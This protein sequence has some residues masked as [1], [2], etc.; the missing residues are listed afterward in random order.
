MGFYRQN[1]WSGVPFP[2][3]GDLPDP[4]IKP[5]SPKSLMSPALAGGFFTTSTTWEA[6]GECWSPPNPSVHGISPARILEWV[7]MSFSRWSSWPRDQSQV[8]CINSRFFVI[9]ATREAPFLILDIALI[10]P[11][12]VNRLKHLLDKK[13][14]PSIKNKTCNNWTRHIVLQ[15]ANKRN[16]NLQT[17]IM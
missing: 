14:K 11:V 5:E 10:S 15:N 17:W 1:Y 9:W 6:P 4:G 3:P 13:S 2:S 8:S 16:W 7:T 12:M